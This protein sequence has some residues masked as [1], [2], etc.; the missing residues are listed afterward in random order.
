MRSATSP[1][2]SLAPSARSVTSSRK[3]LAPLARSVTSC[4]KCLAPSAKRVTS[5][6]KCLAPSAKSV[7]YSRKCLAPSARSVTSSRKCLAP[8][9]RSVTSSR[10]SLAPWAAK[11]AVEAAGFTAKLRHVE[12]YANVKAELAKIHTVKQL[13]VA[14]TQLE[15]IAQFETENGFE[16]EDHSSDGNNVYV[17]QYVRSIV[18]SAPVT[19]ADEGSISCT[20]PVLSIASEYTYMP[21]HI[22]VGNVRGFPMPEPTQQIPYVSSM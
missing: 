22:C 7:T 9:A 11:L 17:E 20:M 18:I 12:N 14:E 8:S 5:S 16:F 2:R 21:T 15:A 3:C 19:P 6:R 4:R 13:D 1:R 10:S